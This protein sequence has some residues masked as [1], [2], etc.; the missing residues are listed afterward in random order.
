MLENSLVAYII[1]LTDELYLQKNEENY[2]IV[3]IHDGM[4][5]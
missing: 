2:S 4:T 1:F 3:L 5:N